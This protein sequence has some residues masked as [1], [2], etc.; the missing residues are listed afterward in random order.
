M[1]YCK[2]NIGLEL[3]E[4]ESRWNGY[5]LTHPTELACVTEAEPNIFLVSAI[6]G[7]GMTTGAGFMKEMLENYVL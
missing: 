2:E 5:Y 3:P 7:K 6:A 1:Q 4:I